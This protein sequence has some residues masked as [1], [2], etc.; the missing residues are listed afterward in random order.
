MVPPVPVDGIDARV[1]AMRSQAGFADTLSR[2]HRV[3]LLRGTPERAEAVAIL[4]HDPTASFFVDEARWGTSMRDREWSLIKSALGEATTLSSVEKFSPAVAA[5]FR[6]G[7]I[8]AVLLSTLL[9][10]IY[11]WVR[12]GSFRYSFAAIVTTLHD[13]L[14]A[15]GL[16]AGAAI[17]HRYSPTLAGILGI[18]PF[19][20]DLNLVAAVL[21]TLG[22]SL[23]DTIVVMDRIRE[24]K[25]KL[26]YASRKVINDA[27]NQTLSRTIIT[28][29]TTV[30]AVVALYILGGEALRVFSYTMLI[31][32]IIGT[33]SSIAVAAPL[34]WVRSADK[35][36]PPATPAKPGQ[37]VGQRPALPA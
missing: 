31:G 21:T 28:S 17:L 9:I 37:R 4:S 7:A 13:C 30:I 11:V 10:I 35:T 3:V 8:V 2:A 1:Q 22:Y 29:G 32:I 18:T 19:K 34:V 15:V 25:G 23:N 14:V 27:I 5:D 12:F 36:L 26:P 20:F 24:T 6:A 33:Y 16:V